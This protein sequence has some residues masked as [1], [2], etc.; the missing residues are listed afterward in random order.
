MNKTAQ[1]KGL[2]DHQ[3]PALRCQHG[4]WTLEVHDERPELHLAQSYPV[5]EPQHGVVHAVSH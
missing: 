4:F 3:Q 5:W 1:Y 2:K